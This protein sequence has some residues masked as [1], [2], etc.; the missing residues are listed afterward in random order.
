MY[1][2]EHFKMDDEEEIYEFIERNSF[3]AL[4]S[5]HNGE[6]CATHLPLLLDKGLNTLYGHFARA[7]D[8]WKD[9]E[10][11]AVLAIFHGPH[12]YISPSWYETK[13]AVP[14]WNYSAV[15]VYGK[16]ELLDNEKEVFDSLAKMVKKYEKPESSYQLQDV[17]PRYLA[18]MAKGI[19]G[20]KINITKIEAKAK[21]SQNHPPERQKAVIEQLENS[22]NPHDQQIAEQMKKN[23]NKK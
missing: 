21:L 2:P 13:I 6:P 15:H 16:M 11:Q 4:I 9:A 18:G 10:D 3:A 17:D 12:G 19:V 20:F 8:Q 14:T 5:Q 22:P 7:N 23:L 1:V